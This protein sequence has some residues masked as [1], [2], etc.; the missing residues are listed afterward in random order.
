[1]RVLIDCTQISRQRAGV[2][3][4]ALNMIREMLRLQAER[5]QSQ[6]DLFLL[7]QDDD[8]DFFLAADRVTILKVPA[9]FFRRLPLRFLLE[10]LYIPWLTWRLRLDVVHSLHYAFPLLPLSARKVVTIHD[11]TSYKMPEAHLRSKLLYFRFFL[12]ASQCGADSLIFVSEAT[13]KDYLARFPRFR[14]DSSVVT[15]GKSSE[16]RPDLDPQR[17][18]AVRQKYGVTGPYILYL[19]MIE[20]RKNLSRLVEAF[21]QI[22]EK[23][24]THQLVIAGKKGWMYQGIFE[25]V[26]QLNIAH[27]VVFPGYIDEEDKPF[28]IRGAE[29]FAYPSL[30]EGFG[31][32]VL[33]AMACGVPVI[34]S[35]VSSMPEVAADAALLVN[36]VNTDE[37]AA[38]LLRLLGSP[39]L[40]SELSARAIHQ[41]ERFSWRHTAEE[42]LSIYEQAERLPVSG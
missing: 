5:L 15:L 9:R 23:H 4:Y 16:F 13:R 3:V 38:A 24:P 7:V 36:P 27:R 11:L 8:S 34:T 25:T 2:S 26:Q 41:A 40:R 29:V 21:A 10:Q 28:L 30:Y 18:A 39:E 37:I 20:P 17:I 32:P 1:M 31:I 22:A 33:E 19:G 42:T 12:R 6:I 35:S 14:G